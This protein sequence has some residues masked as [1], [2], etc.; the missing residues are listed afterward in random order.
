MQIQF[1]GEISDVDTLKAE[2]ESKG[3]KIVSIKTSR[4]IGKDLVTGEE[5]DK[6]GRIDVEIEDEPAKTVNPKIRAIEKDLQSS[7]HY[8]IK[9]T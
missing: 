2:L 5:V 7:Q 8:K 9:K 3:H 6:G 4:W 1:D